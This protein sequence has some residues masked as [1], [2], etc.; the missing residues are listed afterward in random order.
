MGDLVTVFWTV[1][2]LACCLL[3][4]ACAAMAGAMGAIGEPGI[5]A[6]VLVCAFVGA[7]CASDAFGHVRFGEAYH[8]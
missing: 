4:G 5:G 7:W 2:F 3:V 8:S 1:M 6:Y